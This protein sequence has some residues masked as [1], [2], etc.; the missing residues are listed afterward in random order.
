MTRAEF[1]VLRR[2]FGFAC[3]YCS[4]SETGA[5]ALLTVDHFQPASRAGKDDESNWVYCCAAC[6]SFKS[7]FWN[8]ERSLLRP[9]EED[10]SLHIEER[11]GVLVAL[12]SR[13]ENHLEVLHLNRESLVALRRERAANQALQ[14]RLRHTEERLARALKRIEQAR[15][16]PE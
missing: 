3:G 1:A 5:G 6:N 4:V 14:E 9:L 7:A 15:Q 12:T 8:E 13:G 16:Q 2:R 11:E 10:F